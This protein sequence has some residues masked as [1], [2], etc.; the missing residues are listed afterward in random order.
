LPRE[1][2]FKPK[3][4]LDGELARKSSLS[5][6]H[7]TGAVG[8]KRQRIKGS[9]QAEGKK[10]NRGT[11]DQGFFLVEATILEGVGGHKLSTTTITD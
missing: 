9:E 7:L 4:D 8:E 11:H 2:V 6:F 1:T 3:K 5:A 10:L